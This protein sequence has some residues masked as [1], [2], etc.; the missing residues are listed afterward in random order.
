[1]AQQ[2]LKVEPIMQLDSFDLIINLVTLN[3]GISFVPM[4]AMALYG[5]KSTL[6][7]ITLPQRFTRELIVVVRKQRLMPEHLARFVENVLF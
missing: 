5:R 4:R 3:M 7:R 2:G 1:M 6:S